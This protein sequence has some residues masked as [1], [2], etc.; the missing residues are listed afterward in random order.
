M[1]YQFYRRCVTF[2]FRSL[3][4]IFFSHSFKS[5]GKNVSFFQPDRIE[6]V[7]HISLG[8]NISFGSQCWLMAL[9][10]GDENPAIDIHDGVYIGRF[11]HIVSISSI[12]IEANV[13]IAD[14]VY[15]SDNSHEYENIA[16]PVIKQ[17]VC[18][19]SQVVIG[20]NS[21]IGENV[22]IVGA[23]IGKHC[24]IGAHSL[25]TSDIPSYSVAVG[26]PAK[27]IKRFNFSTEEWE[28]I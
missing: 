20:E 13:L 14:K 17:P 9:K 3:F 24:V 22:S 15:I 11:S 1:S 5:F 8:N 6:G 23:K 28:K 7:K 4:N 26:S 10:A 21:W 27:V 2:I 16:L 12:V 19:K 18:F 25:V